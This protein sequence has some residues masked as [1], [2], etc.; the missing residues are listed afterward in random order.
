MEER[1][2]SLEEQMKTILYAYEQNQLFLK[3]D[4]ETKD[5]IIQLNKVMTQFMLDSHER[6]NKIET[7]IAQLKNEVKSLKA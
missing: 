1:I 2:A 4:S 3:S 7:E 5:I 6:L